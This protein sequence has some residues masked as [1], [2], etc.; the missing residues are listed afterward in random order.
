[1]LHLLK[2]EPNHF[3]CLPVLSNDHVSLS[4]FL[5]FSLL[6]LSLSLSLLLTQDT[7]DVRIMM[8]KSVKHT[9]NFL[10][11]KENDLHRIEIPFKFHMMQ[12]GLVHGLAFWFDVAFMGSV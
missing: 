6:S 5:S 8:A 1:R 7:F 2:E 4:L 12:S 10:E 11:V 9:V 3:F